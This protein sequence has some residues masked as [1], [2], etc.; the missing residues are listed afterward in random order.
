MRFESTDPKY[1]QAHEHV[2]LEIF[3][4]GVKH[5]PICQCGR[6]HEGRHEGY[7]FSWQEEPKV[8]AQTAATFLTAYRKIPN[9]TREL[10][11]NDD[12]TVT[13]SSVDALLSY[14][15]WIGINR[16]PYDD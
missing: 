16:G 7:G 1:N 3:H 14:V 4:P 6:D 13:I 2:C 9:G 12:G 15:T 11:L 5:G 8:D 10:T